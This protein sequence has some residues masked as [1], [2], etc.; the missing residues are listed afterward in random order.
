MARRRDRIFALVITVL[1]IMTSF[2]L[3]LILIWQNSQNNNSTTATT[4][5]GST[6]GTVGTLLSGFKPVS[7]VT[8]LQAIDEKVGTGAVVKS[9]S[10]VS[11][12]YTGAVAASGIIFSSTASN[13]GQP[14]SISLS[15]V[16]EGWQLGIPGM[17]VG[18]I[19]Q[20]IIPANE[21]YGA[22]P[23]ANSSIPA[24]AALVFNITLESV[25]K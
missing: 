4:S 20:L 25:G 16:I 13:N 24:N 21:A 23:P 15:Q 7:N 12:F 22:N 18:G 6:S 8:S 19:R 5:T 17:K 11:V 10:T 3:S 14:V 2:G 9:G 1:F